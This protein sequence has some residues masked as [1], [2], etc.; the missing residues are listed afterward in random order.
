MKGT[1]L[2]QFS[3]S[4]LFLAFSICP[5]TSDIFPG[6]KH[7]VR[8]V[9]D[10]EAKRLDVHCYSA[11]DVID[12]TLSTKGEQLEFEFRSVV[13]TYWNCSMNSVVGHVGIE[14][15][16]S[17]DPLIDECGGV[18]CIWNAREDGIYLYRIKHSDYVKKYDWIP[19]PLRVRSIKRN[20]RP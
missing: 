17:E 8:V 12:R 18:H 4:L 1:I 2:R 11:D 10:L 9:N 20:V 13:N 6:K 14:A 5:S 19:K 16:I 7:F 3:Y 15:Y